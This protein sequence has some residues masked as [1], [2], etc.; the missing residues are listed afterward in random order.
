MSDAAVA[1]FAGE[2][3]F[4][5]H[6]GRPPI[7]KLLASAPIGSS[8]IYYSLP[9]LSLEYP[10]GEDTWAD[11][12]APVRSLFSRIELSEDSTGYGWLTAPV[13]RA[14]CLSAQAS[15]LDETDTVGEQAQVL[16]S[17][18]PAAAFRIRTPEGDAAAR[19]REL[20]G[21]QIG[22][23]ADIFGV[24]RPTY[25]NWLN[26]VRPRGEHRD[27]LLFAL[28]LMEEAGRVL[29]EPRD[30]GA[31]LLSPSPASGRIPIELLKNRQFDLCRALLTRGSATR[32]ALPARTKHRLTGQDLRDAMERYSP[33]PSL[34]DL[35]VSD[36]RGE[37]VDR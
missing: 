7:R 6:P 30:V 26:G 28:Q 4:T 24:A 17:S 9:Q 18:A 5:G 32:K 25:Y 23:L 27:H 21:L 13:L 15:Q 8:R 20:S 11:T 36:E 2:E 31:W 16:V 33:R 35:G 22:K 1:L 12:A 14:F 3:S 34:E 37:D 19:L 10:T 29:G